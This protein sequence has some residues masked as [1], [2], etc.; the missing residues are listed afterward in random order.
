MQWNKLF[1][2]S[3]R[4]R[5]P[6][7][8][9]LRF[10][11]YATCALLSCIFL[12]VQAQV[13][14]ATH[15]RAIGPL[16]YNSERGSDPLRAF[17]T[18]LLETLQA[19][20]SFPSESAVGGLAFW[21]DCLINAST[22]VITCPFSDA[23]PSQSYSAWALANFTVHE[24]AGHPHLLQCSDPAVIRVKKLEPEY[25]HILKHAPDLSV[26]K[27]PQDTYND[28]RSLCVVRLYPGMYEIFFETASDRNYTQFQCNYVHPLDSK[29]FNPLYQIDD[30][31]TPDIMI[32][33][34]PFRAILAG[35]HISVTVMNA[36][37][38]MWASNGAATLTNAVPGIRIASDVSNGHIPRIAPR[39]TRQLRIDLATDEQF[40]KTL[41]TTS[42]PSQFNLTFSISYEVGPSMHTSEFE[43]SLDVAT[44]GVS[45]A[46]H[47][48]F[49]D[50]DGSIQTTA[51][52]PPANHCPHEQGCQALLSTHGAGVN[53]IA[54]AWTESYRTQNTSWVILPTGRRK[55]GL[56][57]EG[58]QMKS[59][60]T[61]L[62]RFAALLPGVPQ[63]E[64][65][66]WRV[67]DDMWLQAGHSMGGHGALVLS[68]HFP[69]MLVAALPAMGWLRVSTYGGSHYREQ[70]SYSDA[71]ARALQS[72]ASEEYASDLYAENLLGIPL[73]A[74]VGSADDNVPRKF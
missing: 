63:E 19:L 16:S 31:V 8:P 32:T 28:G 39:Q 51:V 14:I 33:K 47:F 21:R 41:S 46:Y 74:R 68:T 5:L 2:L 49:V 30:V 26:T 29:P 69:D 22:P 38:A 24:D 3:E 70:I 23:D 44:W 56:N 4:I 7:F 54:S 65:H 1:A 43:V 72:V 64:K 34:K 66:L 15:F 27:C 57:W 13:P 25:T 73:L 9:I 40:L 42:I 53:A 55:Y 50:V 71:T 61:S 62:S 35:P 58:P 12:A 67:R 36:H 52:L 59:A 10:T 37:H 11:L 45:R 60:L 17:H 48:T 18:P 6:M 20:N